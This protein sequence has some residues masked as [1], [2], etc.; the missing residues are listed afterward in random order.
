VI[1]RDQSLNAKEGLSNIEVLSNV[2]R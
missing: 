2:I 1:G